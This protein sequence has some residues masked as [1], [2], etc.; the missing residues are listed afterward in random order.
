MNVKV[1]YGNTVT[2][3]EI[4]VT[5]VGM[6][7]VFVGEAKMHP[8]DTYNR[9]IGELYAVSRAMG[10]AKTLLGIIADGKVNEAWQSRN[11]T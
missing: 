3:A 11:S 2:V 5:V 8:K 1:T 9:E 10:H 7:W 4:E 6:S